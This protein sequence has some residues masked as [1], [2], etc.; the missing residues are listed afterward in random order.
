MPRVFKLI[1]SV[2]I[3]S[4]SGLTHLYTS[5]HLADAFAIRLPPGTSR[6]PELLARFIL[7]HRPAWVGWLIK[8]RDT[9]V[10]CLGLKTA[11]HLGSLAN[12][13]GVFNVYSTNPTEILL[14]EDD[15]HLD[16]RISVLCTEAP[17]GSN[18][19]VFSTVVHCHNAIGRAYIFIISP[20]HRLIVKASLLRA[21]RVGW[22]LAIV[23]KDNQT[24]EVK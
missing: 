2:P 1:T 23:P 8:V 4:R 22:P 15:K 19:L 7:S 6:S 13:I 21:A 11:K 5:M 3:P 14:G 24:G 17:E 10:A 18:Q 16:F 12:R 9:V 20:F